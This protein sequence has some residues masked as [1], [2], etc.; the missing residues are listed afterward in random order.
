MSYFK[1][2]STQHLYTTRSAV[3]Q[4]TFVPI[5]NTEIHGIN[6]IKCRSVQIWN[7][8]QKALPDDLLN[9]TRPKAKEQITTTLLKSCLKP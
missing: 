1:T 4:S 7:K 8:L 6:F 9:L 2:F 3:N 5:D